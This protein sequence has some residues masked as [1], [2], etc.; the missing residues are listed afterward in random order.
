MRRPHLAAA[1]GFAVSLAA[2]PLFAAPDDAATPPP[3]AADQNQNIDPDAMQALQKM[4]AYLTSLSTARITNQ[5][6][7][8]LVSDD[9]QRVQLDGVVTYSLRKPDGFVIDVA[10]DFKKR[11][12][13]YDGKRFT[14]YAPELG[15]YASA[16]A[17][18][19][20]RETLD[21][22]YNKYGIAL[23]LEDLFRWTDPKSVRGGD[24]QR[25]MDMGMVTLDGV[26]TEHYAFRQA[27]VDWEIWIQQGDQPLPRKVVIVDRTDPALPAYTARLTWEVNPTFAPD[28]FAFTPGQSDKL[29]SLAVAQQ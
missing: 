22:I 26:R 12:F 24:V 9:G 8:D 3:A 16:P 18:A 20:T 4:S 27:D 21:A 14:I 5:A 23:P 1:L 29:I 2:T 28:T 6:S 15:Y 11:R 10:T 25:A 19:T 17:P 13:I 7:L